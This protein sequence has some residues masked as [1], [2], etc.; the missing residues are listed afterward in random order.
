MKKLFILATAASLVAT[1]ANAQTTVV[2]PGT[3]TGAA[4]ATIQI[5]PEYRTKIK[6]YVTEKRIR[7]VET[8]ERIVVGAKVPT[9]V[10]LEAV[11]SDWGPTVTKY[12]YVY[13]NNRVMLVD[14]GTRTVVHEID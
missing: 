6:S 11:P 7:P 1:M 14:P 12:R 8:R 9:E 4:G 13:S 5:E 10:E 2:T 3:T